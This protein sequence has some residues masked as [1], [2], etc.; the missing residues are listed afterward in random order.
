MKFS[1]DLKTTIASTILL[2]LSAE[3]LRLTSW[4]GIVILACHDFQGCACAV[5]GAGLDG[6]MTSI[7]IYTSIYNLLTES[8]TIAREVI[9]V[10]E[11]HTSLPQDMLWV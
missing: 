10:Q 4:A 2:C 1:R 8:S 6:I 5:Q 11:V 3:V 9:A 7:S